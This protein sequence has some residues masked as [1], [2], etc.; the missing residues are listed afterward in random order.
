[1]HGQGSFSDSRLG[2]D[3]TASPDLVTSKLPDLLAYQLSLAKPAAPPDASTR[4]LARGDSLFAGKARC[5]TVIS[6]P[7][8]PTSPPPCICPVRPGWIR[9]ATRGANDRYRTTPLRAL[10]QHP[11]YFHDGSA[12]TLADVVEHYDQTFSLGLTAEQKADLVAFLQSL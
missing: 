9:W 4:P 10:W 6:H 11:P 2:I 3:I 12:A 1:M 8:S 7:P 5:A